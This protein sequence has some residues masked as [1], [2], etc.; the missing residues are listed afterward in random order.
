[1][2]ISL[3]LAQSL[4][5]Y[6]AFS[7]LPFF[8]S[9]AVLLLID[10][11][12]RWPVWLAFGFGLLPLIPFWPLLWTSKALYGA[13]F[14]SVPSLQMAESSYGSYLGT[15]FPFGI[16]IAAASALSVLA[17]T[18]YKI[19]RSARDARAP[20]AWLQ[21]PV[22]I[23]TFLSLPF[24]AVLLAEI[25]HG[26]M[27]TKYVLATVLGFPLAVSYCFPRFGS[28]S[29][30]AF[31]VLGLFLLILLHQEEIFWSSYNGHFSSPADSVEVFVDSAGHANLPVVISDPQDFMALSHYA[32]TAYSTRFVSV[33][34]APQ[35]VAYTG[36]DSADKEL[37]IL[38]AYSPLHVYD[39]KAFVAEHPEFLLY[40]G[41]AG[42]GGD[43]WPMRLL[44]DGYTL[45]PFA[46]KPIAEHDFFHRV[47]LVSRMKD[48]D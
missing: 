46:V 34:D 6:A 43:W 32:S 3:A 1:M 22:M 45:R 42:M 10:R 20:E 2:G 47:F 36:S 26:G 27:A 33:V 29:L 11:H 21:E 17:T 25:A 40:S 9:E 8:V 39:F 13:H 7:F 14:W 48:A 30:A 35:A 24:V 38:A 41:N 37:P 18:L 5:Y 31:S 23:L 16:G 44:H 4:H 28:R 15:S 19:R 12:L